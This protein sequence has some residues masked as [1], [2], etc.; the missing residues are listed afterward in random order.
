MLREKKVCFVQRALARSVFLGFQIGVSRC[1]SV[2]SNKS[3]RSRQELSNEY[4]L[5]KLGV[6]TAENGPLKAYQQLAKSWGKRYK[7]HRPPEAT[8]GYSKDALQ[9]YGGRY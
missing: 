9:V 8:R 4:L 6:D 5:A 7:K 3:C 1:K 2:Y